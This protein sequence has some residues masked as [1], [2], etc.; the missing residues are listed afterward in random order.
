MWAIFLLMLG[1]ATVAGALLLGW[2]IPVIA[3][4]IVV[5]G[6]AAVLFAF[7]RTV[8]EPSVPAEGS[9][10]PSWMTRHWWQ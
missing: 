6:A 3:I 4:L 7:M 2:G 5:L 8:A 1:A 9:R 10:K